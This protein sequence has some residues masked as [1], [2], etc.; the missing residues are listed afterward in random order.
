MKRSLLIIFLLL[1]IPAFEQTIIESYPE[2][3]ASLE[4]PDVPKGEVLKY[5]FDNSKIFPVHGGS[6][7]FIY[8]LNT[9]LI[10][11]LVCILTRMVFNGKRQQYLIT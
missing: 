9:V 4:H 6:I 11:R 5:T 7:G 2:D 10:N 1:Q 3:S 8:L